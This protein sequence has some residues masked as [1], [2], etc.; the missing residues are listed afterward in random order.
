MLADTRWFGAGAGTFSAVGRI[1]QSDASEALL[2]P[3]TATAIFAD[4]GWIGLVV[5]GAACVLA[6]IRLFF[7]SL[8]R[9]RDSFFPTA[10]AACLLFALVQSLTGPGLL[11]PAAI[12]CFSV[13]VGLGL[14][15]SVSSR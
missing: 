5:A 8:Q 4:M 10:A 2:V 6:L 15:Q 1:Y 13:I 12:L 11:R 14:S 7:G 9:G 3:S